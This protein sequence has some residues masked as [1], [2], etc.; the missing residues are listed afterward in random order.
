MAAAPPLS[1]LGA[2]PNDLIAEIARRTFKSDITCL[3]TL[4][5]VSRE[6]K[7]HVEAAA[8]Q[9]TSLGGD[10]SAAVLRRR[11]KAIVEPAI[12]LKRLLSCMPLLHT[13]DL[14][15]AYWWL[16]S[17]SVALA[18]GAC[19]AAR[20]LRVLR[21]DHCEELKDHDLLA[22]LADPKDGFLG[23]ATDSWSLAMEAQ[24]DDSAAA[25]DPTREGVPP[26]AAFPQLRELSVRSCRRLE[27]CYF[28]VLLPQLQLLD[29]AWC[30]SLKQFHWH[31][32]HV[33]RLELIDATGVEGMDDDAVGSLPCTVREARLAMTSVTDAGLLELGTQA[34]SLSRVVLGKPSNNLWATG[35]WTEA[36]VAELKRRRP[37]IAVEFVSA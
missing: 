36:G 37:S 23:A 35:Q 21:L 17:H 22:M 30:A 12:P 31:L 29:V 24:A 28:L 7:Q 11:P 25:L 8:R 2:L 26:A 9:R 10:A 14:S 4:S 27:S 5:C 16:S 20:S 13:L 3:W 34:S 19:P 1:L 15:G 6:L 18:I 33:P 32:E